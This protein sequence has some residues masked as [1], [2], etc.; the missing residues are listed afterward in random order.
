ME[1]IARSADAASDGLTCF[2]S[3]SC[4]EVDC[5]IDTGEKLQFVVLKCSNPPA[6][7]LLLENQDNALVYNQTFTESGFATFA[8]GGVQKILNITLTHGDKT[9]GVQ[10]CVLQYRHY[11]LYCV[12]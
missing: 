6:L 4:S 3:P 2:T 11:S 12:Q 10:V 5:A 9:M 1:S 7:R 8:T